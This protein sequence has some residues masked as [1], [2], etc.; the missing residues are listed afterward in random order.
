MKKLEKGT[1]AEK[2]LRKAVGLLRRELKAKNELR[3]K[4]LAESRRITRVSKEATTL[5]F[6]GRIPK[7]KAGLK[8]AGKMIRRL[9]RKLEEAPE[10]RHS[11]ALSA[12]CQ[13]FAEAFILLA[14]E[15]RGTCPTL[16]EVKV[17]LGSYILG[18]ADVPGELRRGVLTALLNHD[19]EGAERRFRVMEA[20]YNEL[21]ALNEQAFHVLPGLRRKCDV[22]RHLLEL[23]A[24]EVVL[25]RRQQRLEE[26]LRRSER[27]LSS[28]TFKEKP[29]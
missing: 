6:Q 27:R 24:S 14:L 25:E 4:M 3:E 28:E 11:G 12:A 9:M 8:K 21:T 19:V 15:E 16:E 23:T 26:A 7:A 13:E 10:L 18:L 1:S 22:I 20:I 2:S 5:I 29:A 17:D